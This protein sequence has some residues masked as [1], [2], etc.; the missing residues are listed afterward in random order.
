MST[1]MLADPSLSTNDIISMKSNSTE[2]HQYKFRHSLNDLSALIS[3]KAKTTKKIGAQQKD[4]LQS[5]GACIINEK[6]THCLLVKQKETQNWSLPKGSLEQGESW[7][8]CMEREVKEETGIV[9]QDYHHSVLGREIYDKYLIYV[10]H[11]MDHY[12]IHDQLQFDQEEIERLEWM[13]LDQVND[14][15]L[16]RVTA[17]ILNK[18][19]I[20]KIPYQKSTWSTYT[21]TAATTNSRVNHSHIDQ[22]FR[23]KSKGWG[24]NNTCKHKDQQTSWFKSCQKYR[25]TD[26]I[27][28]TNTSIV[29][30]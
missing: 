2:L 8:Q 3:Y 25:T 4:R 17:N 20:N 18:I 6:A 11:L 30:K 10:I 21:T 26:T 13:A 29:L 7:Q 28:N 24:F 9:I 15:Q 23:K 14:L 22:R 16:N 5:C 12:D 1:L 27:I 19:L